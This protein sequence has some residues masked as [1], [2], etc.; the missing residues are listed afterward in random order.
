MSAPARLMDWCGRLRRHP[1]RWMF[2]PPLVLGLLVLLIAVAVSPG[3]ERT[4]AGPQ[5]VPVRAIHVEAAPFLPVLTG[6]GEARPARSWQ[7][8]AQVPGR[9]SF[10]HPDL[11]DGAEIASGT[12]LLEIDATDYEL[13]L[14]RAEAARSVTH[15]RLE[16][17]KVRSSD[18]AESIDIEARALAIAEA[19]FER[20]RSL[21]Q[22]GHIS[23]FEADSEEQRLL[24]QRQNLQ[25]MRSQ[26]NLVP[27]QQAALNAQLQEAEAQLAKAAEDLTRTRV[28]MP[29]DGRIERLQV[30][31]TQ[32]VTAGQPMF[33]AGSTD[34]VEVVLRVPPE[35]LWTRFPGV[36]ERRHG[37]DV[38]TAFSADVL[39][40][41]GDLR[42]SWTGEVARIDPGLDAET[43]MAL[44]YIRV[45]DPAT[46]Q[47]FPLGSN[48]YVRVRVHG[49]A[50]PG[51]IAIPR[52][53]FHEGFVYVID[54]AS[55]V[56]RRAVD[57][58]FRQDDHIVLARGLEPG[59]LL[60]LTDLLFP[61]DGMPVVIANDVDR[62]LST[63]RSW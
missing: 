24:R 40:E 32:F 18:L 52:Q 48:L 49:P 8:V 22:S 10:L 63:D 21:F 14:K 33:G 54:D 44:L 36:L 34:A 28:T 30:D 5:P 55:R 45:D 12:R 61:V 2:F 27:A 4:T 7:A 13:A 43:R 39:Y 6:F 62:A 20:R 51:R 53:A 26:A 17:L 58:A 23:R 3:A 29:F 35:Q 37:T 19:E 15:A 47:V 38:S 11:K 46:A 9:V 31:A 41:A 56:R 1:A 42:L 59:E 16:E 50:L 57:V 60:V 25:S